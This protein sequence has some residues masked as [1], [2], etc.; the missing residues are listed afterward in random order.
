MQND[1]ALA[2]TDVDSTNPVEA[3]IV[4]DTRVNE[5]RLDLEGCLASCCHHRTLVTFPD[6]GFRKISKKAATAGSKWIGYLASETTACPEIKR[7]APSHILS[8]RAT[9]PRL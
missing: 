1:L 6:I 5:R 8:A 9:R 7:A 2:R 3:F 4:L